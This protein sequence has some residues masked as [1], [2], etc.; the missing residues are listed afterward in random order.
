M[1]VNLKLF[2]VQVQYN[3]QIKKGASLLGLC[4]LMQLLLY[5]II[6]VLINSS[7]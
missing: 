2:I 7:F 1:F 4:L 3:V 6:Y 5:L